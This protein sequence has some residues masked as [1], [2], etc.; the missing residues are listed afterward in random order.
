MPHAVSSASLDWRAPYMVGRIEHRRSKRRLTFRTR[1]IVAANDAYC[2]ECAI[3]NISEH[4]ACILVPAG[5]STGDRFA[6]VIDGSDQHH[7]YTVAWREG[8]RIG[9]SYSTGAHTTD[10]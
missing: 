4:G 10:L 7:D 9:V 8:C 2:L 6:L 3:L 1:R 5:A